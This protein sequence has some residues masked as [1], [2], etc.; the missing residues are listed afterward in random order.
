M[1]PAD[2]KLRLCGVFLHMAT[3]LGSR[4]RNGG[5]ATQPAMGIWNHGACMAMT[6][7][8]NLVERFRVSESES[9]SG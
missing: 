6:R 1:L 5:R 3:Q 7:H 2:Y 4:E 9:Q 8:G